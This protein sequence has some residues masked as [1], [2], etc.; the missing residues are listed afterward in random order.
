[1]VGFRFLYCETVETILYNTNI[2]A[3]NSSFSPPSSYVHTRSTVEVVLLLRCN[4]FR[5]NKFLSNGVNLRA[6]EIQ[7]QFRN[8]SVTFPSARF[9]ICSLFLTFT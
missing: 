6:P 7:K 2:K 8:N 1:M 4:I 3:I 9:I 5:Q